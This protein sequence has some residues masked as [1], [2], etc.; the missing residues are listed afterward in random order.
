MCSD[1]KNL[2]LDTS[3]LLMMDGTAT[4]GVMT[5]DTTRKG[6]HISPYRHGLLAEDISHAG[7]GGLFA[8]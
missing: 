5:L 4:R 8:V 3:F 2:L 7:D 6:P 1:M